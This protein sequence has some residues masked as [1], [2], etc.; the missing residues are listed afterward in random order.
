[1]HASTDRFDISDH[2]TIGGSDCAAAYRDFLQWLAVEKRYSD[3]TVEAYSHDLSSFLL[4]MAEH[5]GAPPHIRELEGLKAGDFRAWLAARQRRGLAPSSTARALSTVRSFFRWLERM[6]RGKNHAIGTIRTPKQRQSHPKPLS[7]PDAEALLGAVGD[8]DARDWTAKR[9][10]A[11]FTL[12]YGCGL[13]I[14]EALAL[15]EGEAP[16][17]D[18]LTVRGKGNKERMVPVLPVVREAIAD[19]LAASPYSGGP[20]SGDCDGPLFR[21]VRGGRLADGSARATMRALRRYLDL[22]ETA[23]PHALRHSFASHLLA[24]GG[25]LRAIQELLGH[26]SLSTTQRYTEVDAAKLLAEYTKAHPRAK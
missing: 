13:R 12:L 9:D 10:L 22:P 11:L 4:F 20:H 14:A 5:L 23:S 24:A 1:M 26:A 25:D 7:V 3:K 17:T 6:E 15:S 21:G 8:L 18:T 16:K 19:Y 2:P